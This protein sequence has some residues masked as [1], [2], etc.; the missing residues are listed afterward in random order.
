MKSKKTKTRWHRILG[1]LF[2][3]LLVPTGILVYTDVPV[4]GDP[5]EA[6]LLLL[7]KDQ[8]QWTEEQ[9]SRL[10]DGIRDSSAAHILIEFKYTESIN[11]NVLLQ[12]LCY[13]YLYKNNQELKENEVQTFLV[14]S[15]TPQ[16]STLEKFAWQS[17]DSSGVYESQ[18]PLADSVTLLLLNELA[19]SPHNAWIK[20]FASRKQEKK[21]AFDIL[22]D[23]GFTSL[24][25]RLQWF[26]EGLLHYLFTIGDKD[27][28]IE[29]KPE[30]VMKIGKKWRQTVLLGLKP[31]E[32]MAG[33]TPKDRLAGLTL[34]DILSE[35]S[36][37]EI[38]SYLKKMRKK[39]RK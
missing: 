37:E 32:R 18:N 6:D 34:K 17:A 2:K 7:R 38:E 5:P 1:G 39:Q 11:K 26:I 28:E 23:K 25:R 8:G 14:S 19:D 13:D 20:C 15:K 4:M 9:K 33:L 3:E 24:N 10:P 27:M 22:M 30:D 31:E 35:F 29:I 36:P 21:S 12:T 16:E